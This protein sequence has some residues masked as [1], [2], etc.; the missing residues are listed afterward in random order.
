MSG[1]R[2]RDD[3][4]LLLAR[5]PRVWSAELRARRGDT[6]A[7][8]ALGP[9]GLT[10]SRRW[11]APEVRAL[12][13]GATSAVPGGDG[14]AAAEAPAEA[15]APPP[16][17]EATDT[18]WIEV[19]LVGEDDAPIAGERYRLELPDGR[20]IEGRTN[21]DGRIRAEGIPA[22]ECAL[23]FLDLDETAWEARGG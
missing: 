4:G 22:G 15:S 23:T 6:D 5:A 10:T 19:V 11:S 18:A 3:L 7:P 21:A 8:L 16:A 9:A 1:G 20:T 17:D 2:R 14:A 13:R 12:A